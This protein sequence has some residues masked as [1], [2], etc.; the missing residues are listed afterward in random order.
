MKGGPREKERGGERHSIAR[1]PP[2][3]IAQIPPT[4][5]IYWLSCSFV[6]GADELPPASEVPSE[7]VSSASSAAAA[8]SAGRLGGGVAGR[9]SARCTPAVSP[10][11]VYR[12]TA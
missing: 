7:P 12:A 5:E 2:L 4:V 6:D 1:P 10:S 11:F 3:A 9:A 8:A